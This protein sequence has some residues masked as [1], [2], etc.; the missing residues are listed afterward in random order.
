MK[1]FTTTAGQEI[2]YG[3]IAL[4]DLQ[5]AQDA[6]RREFKERGE[7]LDPPTY[8]VEVLGGE[9][10]YHPHTLETI[11]SATDEEREL[12]DKHQEALSR[13]GDEIQHRTGLV[14][15]DVTSFPMPE[16]DKWLEKR[17]RL[18][19]EDIPEDEE[20]KRLRYLNKV[21]LKTPADNNGLME[22]VFD[23]SMTGAP[24]EVREAYKNLFRRQME[25]QGRAI[26]KVIESLEGPREEV[27]LQQLDATSN[28][29]KGVGD[30]AQPIQK[31]TGKRQ[32]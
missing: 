32:G 10:E 16:D 19:G 9:K 6:V 12:W 8:E 7:P 11:D 3:P 4:D 25:E 13:L 28:G 17:K 2:E 14:L 15:L 1:V 26:A 5:L 23:C 29:S 27:V 18:Y 30:V 22:A 31:P 21:L 20:E 24:E